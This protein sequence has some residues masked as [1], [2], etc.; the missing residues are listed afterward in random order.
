MGYVATFTQTHAI[1]Q[2]EWWSL[3][4]VF[5]GGC[6]PDLLDRHSKITEMGIESGK[7]DIGREREREKER[8]KE[9]KK[10]P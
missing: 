3:Q 5:L 2:S 9:R 7:G 6:S 1:Q 4:N 10:I 8:K